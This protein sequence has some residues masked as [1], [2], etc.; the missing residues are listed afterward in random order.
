M[1]VK[2]TF[3]LID[4]LFQPAE[5]FV[6]SVLWILFSSLSLDGANPAPSFSRKQK[7]T[8]SRSV[9]YSGIQFPEAAGICFVQTLENAVVALIYFFVYRI[10]NVGMFGFYKLACQLQHVCPSDPRG[11]CKRGSDCADLL[12]ITDRLDSPSGDVCQHLAGN[13]GQGASSDKPDGIGGLYLSH[14]AFQQPAQVVADAFENSADHIP[15]AVPQT[16]SGCRGAT[17]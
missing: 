15:L 1:P 14:L 17:A 7:H 11:H 3:F 12:G 10:G 13:R 9:I 2:S 5:N 4:Q 6:P 16:G 8:A